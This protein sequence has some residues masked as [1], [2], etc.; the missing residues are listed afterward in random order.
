MFIPLFIAILLGLVNPNHTNSNCSGGG[1]VQVNSTTPGTEDPG[2]G[3][4]GDDGGGTGTD[5]G[6]DGPGH[7]GPGG[8][9][10]QN[11]PPKP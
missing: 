8:N 6:T 5:P 2:N 4:G 10:G 11:P 1:T 9:T 7:G 3:E